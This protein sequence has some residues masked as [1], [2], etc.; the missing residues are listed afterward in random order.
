VD[1]QRI[2]ITSAVYSAIAAEYACHCCEY[3]QTNTS[4]ASGASQLHGKKFHKIIDDDGG[5]VEP[6][7][8]VQKHVIT[9]IV[10][11]VLNRNAVAQQPPDVQQ[12]VVPEYVVFCGDNVSRRYVPQIGTHQRREVRVGKHFLQVFP[13]GLASVVRRVRNIGRVDVLLLDQ[14][15]VDQTSDDRLLDG[16]RR[17]IVGNENVVELVSLV[18]QRI[19]QPVVD[20][21]VPWQDGDVSVALIRRRIEVSC[22]ETRN[23]QDLN[24]WHRNLPDVA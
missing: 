4:T 18:A 8:I 11:T 16:R 1:D 3:K 13:H 22:L 17:V 24:G 5:V 2:E 10:V 23:E 14:L 21:P 20:H 12:A 7:E 19:P 9:V 6:S 15:V